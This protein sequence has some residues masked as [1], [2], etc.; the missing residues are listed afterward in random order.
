MRNKEY[1]ITKNGLTRGTAIAVGQARR[2]LMRLCMQQYIRLP[3]DLYHRLSNSIS[4]VQKNAAISEIELF[5][6]SH[7]C[8][9]IYR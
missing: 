6:I 9:S 5:E 7:A 8:S 3:L 1:T 4:H 2:G